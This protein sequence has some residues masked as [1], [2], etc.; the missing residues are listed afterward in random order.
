MIVKRQH[1]EMETA[2]VIHALHANCSRDY[3]FYAM[4]TAVIRNG[5]IISTQRFRWQKLI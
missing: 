3:F 5:L 1:I 2:W 4:L